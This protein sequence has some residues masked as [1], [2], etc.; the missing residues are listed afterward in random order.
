MDKKA[1]SIEEKPT[2]PK[3]NY[4]VP[5]IYFFDNSVIEVAKT[6]KPSARGEYEITDIN[7]HYLGD[8]RFHDAGKSIHTGH[9]GTSGTQDW[10]Y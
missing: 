2:H 4:A 9:R 6:I 8:V 3:S 7:K 10:M 1:L 5:G